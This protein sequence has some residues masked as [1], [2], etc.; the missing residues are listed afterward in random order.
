[1]CIRDRLGAM[2][3]TRVYSE[4]PK[5]VPVRASIAFRNVNSDVG[6]VRLLEIAFL[7]GK[8]GLVRGPFVV[9]IPD[10]LIAK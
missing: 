4:I 10:I 9:K 3:G 7:V 1:M 8:P 6:Y 2:T 5:D